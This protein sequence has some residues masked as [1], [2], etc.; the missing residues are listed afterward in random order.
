MTGVTLLDE[1]SPAL[2]QGI[3]GI[4]FNPVTVD[5][6]T[7]YQVVVEGVVK[8][9]VVY[10]S[11]LLCVSA[12]VSVVSYRIVSCPVPQLYRI[13]QLQLYRIPQSSV[14]VIPQLYPAVASLIR[15]PLR[16]V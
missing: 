9:N 16:F 6:E 10:P 4:Y 14:I 8:K 3:D 5:H 2:L 12:V 11:E 15:Y 7:Y 13:P 1:G